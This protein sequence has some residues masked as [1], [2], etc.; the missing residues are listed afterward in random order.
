MEYKSAVQTAIPNEWNKSLLMLIN[1][2]PIH[3]H[4]GQGSAWQGSVGTAY[5]CNLFSFVYEYPKIWAV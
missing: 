4:E 1:K 2:M 5:F 3:R